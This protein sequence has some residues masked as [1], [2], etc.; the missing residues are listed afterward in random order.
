MFARHPSEP[1]VFKPIVI[2]PSCLSV[3]CSTPSSMHLGMSLVRPQ[4]P[5][6]GISKPNVW[7]FL[8]RVWASLL[9]YLRKLFQGSVSYL[10]YMDNKELGAKIVLTCAFTA[11]FIA[12]YLNSQA[13][14]VRAHI[15]STEYSE[16]ASEGNPQVR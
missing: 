4:L 7:T 6:A 1:Y 12:S 14:Q 9:L 15:L 13:D 8:S 16:L 3:L 10:G 11:A 5:E 2:S